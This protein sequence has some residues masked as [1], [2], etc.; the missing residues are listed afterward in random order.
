MNII[1]KGVEMMN[2]LN[3]VIRRWQVSELYEWVWK[4]EN[5]PGDKLYE[6]IWSV[7]NYYEFGC[8]H[9][10]MLLKEKEMKKW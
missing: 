10:G 8:V 4:I 3:D 1:K 6:M 9:L 7:T 5:I 2:S